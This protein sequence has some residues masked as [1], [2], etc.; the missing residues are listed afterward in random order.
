[1]GKGDECNDLLRGGGGQRQG[2]ERMYEGN[3]GSRDDQFLHHKIGPGQNGLSA[4]LP[5]PASVKKD[6]RGDAKGR[7][8]K[9]AQKKVG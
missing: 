2:E 9:V 5:L 3:A 7:R 4:P 1:M 6:T 8:K